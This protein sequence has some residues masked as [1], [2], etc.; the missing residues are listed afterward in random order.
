MASARSPSRS[1]PPVHGPSR[2]PSPQN[3]TQV[4]Q[5]VTFT[6]TASSSGGT[7]TGTVTFKDG[8]VVLGSGT[9][10]GGGIATFTTS[11]LALGN[12]SITASYAGATTFAA[13]TSAALIQTVNTPADSLKLRALQVLATPVA[14][15]TSGMAIS[16]AIDNAIAEG[17]SDGGAFV[18]PSGSG[19]R[20]NF[21][22][23]PDGKPAN[24]AAR[25]TDPFS[26]AS[27]SF[28]SGGRSFGARPSP[29][30]DNASPSRV[31]D[32]FG[33]LAA[34]EPA[35]ATPRYVEQRDW[36]GWAEV[37]GATL[38]HWGTGA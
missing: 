38:D 2:P 32:A 21:A 26:S 33:A 30:A 17:F 12:H 16:S 36:L 23:D 14:A 8:T 24:T 20:F 13:S 27:G 34:A 1:T 31:D 28:A 15:Q 25:S 35:K 37:R 11:T 29:Y 22:A 3:A 7:P 5:A 18:T 9:L 4:G 6:A 10:S 19:V